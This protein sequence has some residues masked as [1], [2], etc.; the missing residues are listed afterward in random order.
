MQICTALTLSYDIVREPQ[1]PMKHFDKCLV[2]RYA[3]SD[4]QLTYIMKP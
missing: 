1:L 3:S 2:I 4:C